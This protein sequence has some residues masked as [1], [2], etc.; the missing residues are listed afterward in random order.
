MTQA[1]EHLLQELC[2]EILTDTS[3][4]LSIS[5]QLRVYTLDSSCTLDKRVGFLF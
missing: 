1:E 2:S 4:V 3:T 5:L